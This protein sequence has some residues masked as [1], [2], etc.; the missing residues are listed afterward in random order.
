MQ[1]RDVLLATPSLDANAY[2]RIC[3]TMLHVQRA[4]DDANAALDDNAPNRSVWYS[5]HYEAA[6]VVE[7]QAERD[8]DAKW[9]V[10]LLHYRVASKQNQAVAERADTEVETMFE[11]YFRNRAAAER[12]AEAA[13]A[14]GYFRR[15]R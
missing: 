11:E 1:R 4:K 10:A 9:E 13:E 6:S 2:L 15:I 14:E 7:A 12:A 5:G 3:R 8:M